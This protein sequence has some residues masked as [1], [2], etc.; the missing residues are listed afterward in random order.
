MRS[1]SPSKYWLGC[2]STYIKSVL[3][4]VLAHITMLFGCG[5]S[6]LREHPAKNQEGDGAG[7]G[8]V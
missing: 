8:L 3:H 2:W 4:G 5:L 6:Q 1:L 7:G